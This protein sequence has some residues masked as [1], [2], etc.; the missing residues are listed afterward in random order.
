MCYLAFGFAW[1]ERLM[2]SKDQSL[3]Q[4]ALYNL[5]A[6]KSFLSSAGY[7]SLVYEDTYDIVEE[8]M[9]AVANGNQLAFFGCCQKS[10]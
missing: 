1:F 7:Q 3:R 5:N 9:K 6:T 4:S 8:Q 10:K 2:T